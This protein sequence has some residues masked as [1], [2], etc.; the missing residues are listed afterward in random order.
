M[1]SSCRRPP[2]DHGHDLTLMPSE[3]HCSHHLCVSVI[4]GQRLTL[5]TWLSSTTT[6]SRQYLTIFY[7]CTRYDVNVV[8]RTHGSMLNV[9][10]PSGMFVIFSVQLGQ[11]LQS[12]LQLHTQLGKLNGTPI[13]TCGARSVNLS[14]LRKCAARNHVYLSCGGLLMSSWVWIQ[15]G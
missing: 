3:R 6:A 5:T 1:A 2:V 15:S 9:A 4:R 8:H 12:T 14:G 13:A 7:L 11:P 10:M